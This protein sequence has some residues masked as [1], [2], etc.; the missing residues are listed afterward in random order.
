[1]NANCGFPK[2]YFHNNLGQ[3]IYCDL[4]QLHASF[5]V[6]RCK[7]LSRFGLCG[8]PLEYYDTVNRKLIRPCLLALGV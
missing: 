6:H 4:S 5:Y 8:A 3:P 7:K 1:M 2:V